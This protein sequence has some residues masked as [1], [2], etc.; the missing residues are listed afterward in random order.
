MGPRTSLFLDR[1][2]V[3]EAEFDLIVLF[4]HPVTNDTCRC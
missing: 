4:L 3:I 1:I 2:W